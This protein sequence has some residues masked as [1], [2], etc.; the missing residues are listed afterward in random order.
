[1]EIQNPKSYVGLVLLFYLIISSGFTE[2]LVSKQ[3]K[4]FFTENRYAQHVVAFL[5]LLTIII[6]FWPND[7]CLS[8]IYAVAGYIWFIF[9]TKLDIQWSMILICALL[10][11]FLFETN[12]INKQMRISA[13]ESL[14]TEEKNVLIENYDFY[15]ICIFSFIIV[16][17][18]VGNVL[19]VDKKQEQYSVQSG[20]GGFNLMKFLFY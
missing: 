20:G 17:T 14:S 10:F 18:V 8:F 13:D 2:N 12:I 4:H 6:M 1:M 16:V 9:S 5:L 11:G 7:L 15:R 19:Y 3:L